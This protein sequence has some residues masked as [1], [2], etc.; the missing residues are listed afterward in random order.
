MKSH[1]PFIAGVLSF[2]VPGL[3]LLCVGQQKSALIN[4]VLVNACLLSAVTIFRDPIITEHIHWLFLGLAAMSAGYAHAVANSV[5]HAK[6][7][8]Q[9]SS[10]AQSSKS[11]SSSSIS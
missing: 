5:V 1:L 9:S 11:A 10:S 7:A 6:A 8:P 3:G 4:F 2:V